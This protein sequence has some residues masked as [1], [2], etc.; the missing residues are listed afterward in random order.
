MGTLMQDIRYS[1][2]MLAKNPG[3]AA[4]AI[5]TLALGIGANTAIFSVVNAVLLRPLAYKDSAALVNVWGKFEKEGLSRNWISEPEYW[6]LRDRNQSFSELGAY[7][8]GDSSN[9]TS[10]ETPPVQVTTPSASASLFS[11]LGV[12]TVLGRTFTPDEDSPGRNHEALLSFALWQS[13]F[14]GDPKILGKSIQL[15]GES[16]SIVGVLRKDFSLAGKRDLWLPLRL[17]RTHPRDRGSH[18]FRVIARLKPGVTLAQAGADMDRFAAQLQREY[19]DSYGTGDKGWGMFLIPLKEDLVGELRPA[20]LIL[21]SAVSF[22]LLIACVNVAN[23]LLAQASAREKELAVR[24][25]MGAGRGRLIRQLLTESLVL[26]FFGALF[27]LVIAHWGVGALRALIPSNVPRIGE[28]Q[29]DQ[30]VLGFTFAVSLVTGLIFGL[31]PAWHAGRA[32]LQD[33]LKEAGRGSSAAGGN[34]RLRGVLVV[35]EVAFAVLLLVGAGLLIRSF[36][37][38][39]EVSPG[40]HTDHLLTLEVSLPEKAYPDGAPVEEFYKQLLERVKAV[41]GVQAAG[42]VSELPL[43]QAYSSGTVLAEDTSASDIP[44]L[45]HMNNLPFLE[46]DRRTVTPGYFSA[47]QIPLQRGRTFSDADASTGPFVAIV[48]SDFVARFWP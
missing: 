9:L 45:K 17:D 35:S 3:F 42:A 39:L 26:A 22:V 7:Y 15:D 44:R 38:L 37:H 16:Y 46:T 18:G 12:Q 25:A 5:L 2:R 8:L 13:Q 31:F 48:D 36:R 21:L 20:L 14:G 32:D 29:V 40:F 30:R 23:L 47:M 6:D 19:P 28:I 10:S 41:P 1:I 43:S 27:G 33:T 24:A 34:R 4:I 11:L